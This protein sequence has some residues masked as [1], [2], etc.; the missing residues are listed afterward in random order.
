MVFHKLIHFQRII[1]QENSLIGRQE[2]LDF[3]RIGI[4]IG[5]RILLSVIIELF[6]TEIIVGIGIR[7]RRGQNDVFRRFVATHPLELIGVFIQLLVITENPDD[8]QTHPDILLRDSAVRIITGDLRRIHQ[9]QFND[10][11]HPQVIQTGQIFRDQTYRGSL[12]NFLL[13]IKTSLCDLVSAVFQLN[14]VGKMV[15]LQAHIGFHI[16]IGRAIVI[17]DDVVATVL[18]RLIV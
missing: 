9:I 14:H 7:H 2:I 4:L 11:A 3:R 16:H 1:E 5:I 15:G 10:I 17:G 12:V 13:S 8:L 18:F 6:H